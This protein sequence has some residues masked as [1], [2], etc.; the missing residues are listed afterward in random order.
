MNFVIAE[1]FFI[2]AGSGHTSFFKPL[3]TPVYSNY[4]SPDDTLTTPYDRAR[5]YSIRLLVGGDRVYPQSILPG[6]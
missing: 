5:I 3:S 1:S 4:T 2:K 6:G